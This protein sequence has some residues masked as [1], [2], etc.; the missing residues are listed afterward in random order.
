MS[1]PYIYL[2]FIL[3]NQFVKL[4][5]DTFGISVISAFFIWRSKGILI[6]VPDISFMRS[7]ALMI[8]GKDSLPLVVKRQA[9]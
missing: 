4:N 8:E 1:V 2:I 3:K 5:S 7:K 6:T 9:P